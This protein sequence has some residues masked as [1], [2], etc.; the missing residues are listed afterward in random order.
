MEKCEPYNLFKYKKISVELSFRL[1]LLTLNSSDPTEIDSQKKKLNQAHNF[2][3]R[4]LRKQK[5]KF[6]KE[7][8]YFIFS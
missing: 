8:F 3:S 4:A 2:F 7:L 5:V 1:L 6:K